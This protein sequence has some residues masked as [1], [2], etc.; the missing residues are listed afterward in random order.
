MPTFYLYHEA[1]S[2]FPSLP[3]RVVAS[4]EKE[5]RSKYHALRYELL[6]TRSRS[7]ES[8]RYPYP[9]PIAS[10]SWALSEVAGA[11]YLSFRL[12]DRRWTLR[13]RGGAPM[14][15]QLK[16]LRQISEG[17]AVPGAVAVYQL[18]SHRSDHRPEGAHSLT[19]VFVKIPAWFPRNSVKD[20]S[21]LL[22]VRTDSAHFLTATCGAGEWVL[23]GDHVRRWASAYARQ[24]QRLLND[25][26]VE[27]RS[28]HPRTG[29]ADRLGRIGDR[30]RR[31]IYDWTDQASRQIVNYALRRR[32]ATV[33]YEDSVQTYVGTFPWHILRSKVEQKAL[34]A[35][36]TFEYGPQGS[37]VAQT[38]PTGD[39]NE[40]EG[41][42]V[43][44]GDEVH[45]T[46]LV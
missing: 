32:V 9:L 4:L 41:A 31:R 2:L 17:I 16:A 39:L 25:V 21:G 12:G 7:L 38:S 3:S 36:L 13:L 37:S 45:D 42:R 1:R 27:R 34:A 5:L 11:W 35:G 20:A 26:G 33:R 8:Y 23:N 40:L 22:T 29:L 30:Y 43:D 46:G 18:V 15:Y 19:R 6:W 44:C 28:R 24:K 10:N 14:R